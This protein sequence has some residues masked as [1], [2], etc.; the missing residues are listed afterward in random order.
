MAAYPE[1]HVLSHSEKCITLTTGGVEEEMSSFH[2][3]AI[4]V[5]YSQIASRYPIVWTRRPQT[6]GLRVLRE[7]I[8][9]TALGPGKSGVRMA[10]LNAEV[11]EMGG[12][13][14]VQGL[15][16]DAPGAASQPV[17]QG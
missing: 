12:D 2:E 16:Q 3:K 7:I 14:G 6:V 15:S 8:R 1:I 11:E 10:S 9:H 13:A 17:A 5:I 4:A